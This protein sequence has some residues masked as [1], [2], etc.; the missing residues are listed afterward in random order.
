MAHEAGH[1]TDAVTRCNEAELTDD[2][3]AQVAA[4]GE[5]PIKSIKGIG[6]N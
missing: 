2:E 3:L 6:E 1:D 5:D 4:G